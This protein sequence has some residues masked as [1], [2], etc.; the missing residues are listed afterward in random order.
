MCH[1]FGVVDGCDDR[2]HQSDATQYGVTSYACHERS[3]ECSD[4]QHRRKPSPDRHAS[5]LA[6]SEGISE[7]KKLA[8]AR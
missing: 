7:G 8:Q 6:Q 3:N 4:R 2:S 5:V 1:D